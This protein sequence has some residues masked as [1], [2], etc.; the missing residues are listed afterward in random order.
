MVIKK[1]LN[2]I[3]K[4]GKIYLVKNCNFKKGKEFKVKIV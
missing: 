2:G 1:E 4:E 3:I